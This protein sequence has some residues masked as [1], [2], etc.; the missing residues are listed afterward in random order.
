LGIDGGRSGRDNHYS[1][2]RND[3]HEDCGPLAD[4]NY[5]AD[6]IFPIR[7]N[8]PCLLRRAW[9]SMTTL[10]DVLGIAPQATKAEIQQAYKDRLETMKLGDARTSAE[11]VVIQLKVVT[12]A[13]LILS[14]PTRRHAYDSKL[15]DQQRAAE[16]D[17]FQ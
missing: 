17:E 15:K 2:C 9:H 3:D 5:A 6:G 14:S 13:Y 16:G 7:N 11:D 1:I 12:E 10:Y 8:S 4:E